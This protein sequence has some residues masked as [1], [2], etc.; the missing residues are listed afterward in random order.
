MFAWCCL[1]HVPQLIEAPAELKTCSEDAVA[2]SK[3]FGA[4]TTAG[5]LVFP[6]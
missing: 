5:K 4:L 3:K 2:A 6:F 1:F